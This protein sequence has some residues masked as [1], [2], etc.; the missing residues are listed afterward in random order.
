VRFDINEDI[1]YRFDGIGAEC[2]RLLAAGFSLV[3]IV[4]QLATAY[5][6]PRE[7]VAADISALIDELCE[8]GLLQRRL[9]HESESHPAIHQAVSDLA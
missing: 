8:Q 7:Q 4:E 1:A 3:E 9:V 6:A 2:W 5:A